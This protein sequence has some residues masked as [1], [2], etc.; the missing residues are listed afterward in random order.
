MTMIADPSGGLIGMPAAWMER[1]PLLSDWLVPGVV[2]AVWF[3]LGSLLAAMGLLMLFRLPGL[4]RLERATRH[5][6]SWSMTIA[7]GA[8]QMAWIGIEYLYL[9]AAIWLQPLMF[10]VGLA[11]VVVMLL[12]SVR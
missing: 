12:P 3:G 6:W 7:L 1:V 4:S 9:P 11:L 10:G 8:T 5:H 2:L